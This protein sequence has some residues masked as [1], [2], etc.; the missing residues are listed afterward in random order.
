MYIS[1]LIINTG[2]TMN[3]KV[4]IEKDDSGYFTAEVPAFPGCFSQGKTIEEAKLNIKEAIDGWLEV[5]N[6]KMAPHSTNILEEYE[7]LI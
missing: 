2:D 6:N 4:I 3:I 5:M 7:E 1:T